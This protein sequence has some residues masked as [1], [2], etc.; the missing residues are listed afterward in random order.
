[1]SKTP[2]GYLKVLD[3]GY[4]GVVNVL[5]DD[6]S[7]VN[8]ARTSFNKKSTVMTDRDRNLIRYLVRNKE[9]S[10]FRHNAMTFEVRMPLMVARQMFKYVVAS[11]FTEDQL[12]WNENSRRYITED[13]E[14]YVP[15]G[16]QW[17]STPENAKQ[18]SGPVLDSKIGFELT[19]ELKR[20]QAEGERLYN[21]AM[22]LGAA[23]E[24]ARIFQPSNALYV[25]VQ[26]TISL[27]GLF[28]FLNERLEHGAQSEIR[29][30]A[31][32]IAYL[33][34]VHFPES[35]AAWWEDKH[36]KVEQKVGFFKRILSR[37]KR[38]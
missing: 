5:G 25:T 14:Y 37:L 12:G 36:P 21:K 11:N 23:P 30:Y 2:D 3:K 31:Q 29:E 8:A 26:W 28:H 4:V 24:Q 17:R 20:Y 6:L 10:C 13:S 19:D 22:K 33:V 9:Y 18:G 15:N 7:S 34:E 35:Y 1:M 16:Y 27:N 38:S 32:M